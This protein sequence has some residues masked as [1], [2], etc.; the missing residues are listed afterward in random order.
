MRLLFWSD[1]NRNRVC[2]QILVITPNMKLHG[3]PYDGS[4][5]VADRQTD[6]RTDMVKFLV[7]HFMSSPKT[8]PPTA[9]LS[10]WVGEWP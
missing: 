3:N 9:S 8:F 7:V 1:F 5:A 6:G 2:V 4:R 10:E